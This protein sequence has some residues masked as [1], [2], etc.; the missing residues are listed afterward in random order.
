MTVATKT[1]VAVAAVVIVAI[2][3]LTLSRLSS[4]SSAITPPESVPPADSSATDAADKSGETDD[5]AAT[6]DRSSGLR[7]LAGADERARLERQIA[8]ARERRL[9]LAARTDQPSIPQS[10]SRPE[11]DQPEG[12]DRDYIQERMQEL[13]PLIKECYTMA[14]E[15]DPTLSGTLI[16]DLTLVGEPDVG[17]LVGS[18]EVDPEESTLL[19]DGMSECVRETM[20]ALEI[21]PPTG[22]G[23]VRVRYPFLFTNDD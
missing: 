3:A 1:T 14:L 12:H 10:A 23:E 21:D 15:R 9:A 19:E 6:R 13:I 22:G 11:L 7:R 20:Y 18:S 8:D 5:V 2:A 4:R 17:G 16:V